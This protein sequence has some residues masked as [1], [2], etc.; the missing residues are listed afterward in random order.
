VRAVCARLKPHLVDDALLLVSELVT[1][2]VRYGR[3]PM[4]LTVDCDT[5]GIT[6]AVA[7]ANPALP[8]TRPTDQRRHSGRGLVL[9]DQLAAEWGVRPTANGK[10]VWFH[11]A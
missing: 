7:D 6:V 11:L 1:N 4:S 8:R 2:A 3:E 5:E 10:Q 9:V